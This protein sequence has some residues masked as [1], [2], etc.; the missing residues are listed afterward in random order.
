MKIQKRNGGIAVLFLWPRRYISVGGHRHIS[1]ALPQVKRQSTHFTGDWVAPRA[2]LDECGKARHHRVSIFQTPKP[3]AS[4]SADYVIPNF[5][6][7]VRPSFAIGY[8]ISI[9]AQN[10]ELQ[11]FLTLENFYVGPRIIACNDYN[12]GSVFKFVLFIYLFIYS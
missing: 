11:V 7:G 1:A 10:M 2:G 8:S 6:S 9:S 3:I 4:R 12:G 5:P